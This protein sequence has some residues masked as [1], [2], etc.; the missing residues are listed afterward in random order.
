[1]RQGF[2]WRPSNLGKRRLHLDELLNWDR[3]HNYVCKAVI[4]INGLVHGFHG[5]SYIPDPVCISAMR[6]SFST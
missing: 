5:P 6:L 3:P 2:N 4:A 1:M